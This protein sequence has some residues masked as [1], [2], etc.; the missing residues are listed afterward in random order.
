MNLTGDQKC[1]LISLLPGPE[2]RV[3]RD[4]G[5]ESLVRKG[6]VVTRGEGDELTEAGLEEAKRYPFA[7]GVRWEAP[8]PQHPF[9]NPRARVKKLW[10]VYAT[11]KKAREQFAEVQSGLHFATGSARKKPEWCMVGPSLAVSKALREP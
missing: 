4:V 1:A 9:S 6:L 10:G 11:E 5:K 2:R 8:D 3:G 7:V